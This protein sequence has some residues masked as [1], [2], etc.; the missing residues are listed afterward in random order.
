MT[1]QTAPD[2]TGDMEVMERGLEFLLR[3]HGYN[4]RFLGTRVNLP[5]LSAQQ[6]ADAAQRLDGRG[7][8]LDYVHFSVV[9]SRRRRLAYFTAVNIDGRKRQKITRDRDVWYYDPRL[10]RELQTGPE[11]YA[12]NPLDRGHLV[13]R[14]DPVWGRGAATANEDTFHFTNCAPQHEELNRKTWLG[15]ED[16]IL[17]NADVH[18]LKVSVF[19]GPVFRDDDPVYRGRMQLPV[20]YW[21][22]AVMRKRN[23]Q[24]SATAYLQTQRELVAGLEFV[25]GAYQTYQVPVSEIESLTGLDFGRLRDHDPFTTLETFAVARLIEGEGDLIL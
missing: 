3:S 12:G 19:T 7:I 15:L 20:E 4:P 1:D 25:Y 11:I 21:K 10:P 9:M 18:D 5:K 24:L 23:L 14:E 13:R 17:K 2:P 8:E 22:V 6:Q 16:Y